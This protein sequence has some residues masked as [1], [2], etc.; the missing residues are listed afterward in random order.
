[1]VVVL[2]HIVVS[3]YLYYKERRRL[4]QRNGLCDTA[5]TVVAQL[6]QRILL[7]PKTS[8]A[9]PVA[10][11]VTLTAES[12]SASGCTSYAPFRAG[13]GIEASVTM[14]WDTDEMQVRYAF[15]R[16]LFGR[17]FTVI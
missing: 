14:E 9:L 13:S 10:V 7:T 6:E 11:A 12:G 5:G 17:A 16:W 2:I 4:S 8:L 1:M 3:V 15:S